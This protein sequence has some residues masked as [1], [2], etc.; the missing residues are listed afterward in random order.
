M[1]K[2]RLQDLWLNHLELLSAWQ[3]LLTIIEH[4]DIEDVRKSALVL[5]EK[6]IELGVIA[7]DNNYNNI[8]YFNIDNIN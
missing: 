7:S 5:E 3:V 1:N 2:P 8:D 6:L 4:D